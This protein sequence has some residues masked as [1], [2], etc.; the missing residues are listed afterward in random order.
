M[1]IKSHVQIY[2]EKL[3]S[4]QPKTR[5]PNVINSR[6]D[7]VWG[8]QTMEDYKAVTGNELLLSAMRWMNFTNI[9]WKEGR[10]S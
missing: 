5:S 4:P 9:M 1:F 10:Q 7:T 6:T 8:V 2:P 3:H